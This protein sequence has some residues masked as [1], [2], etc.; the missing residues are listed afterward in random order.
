MNFKITLRKL[1]CA[2]LK[3]EKMPISDTVL[4]FRPAH[5]RPAHFNLL[6]VTPDGPKAALDQATKFEPHQIRQI[7]S[8]WNIAGN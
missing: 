7:F 6:D 8:S 1:R 4:S 3:K 5:F 2:F